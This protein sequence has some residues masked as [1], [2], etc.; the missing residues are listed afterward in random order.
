MKKLIFTIILILTFCFTVSAQ[1]NENDCQSIIIKAPDYVYT[2]TRFEVSAT[3]E[4]EIASDTSRFNWIIFNE[5]EVTRVKNKKFVD[6]TSKD[7]EKG[8][9]IIVIAESLDKKCET[10]S[11]AKINFFRRAGSPVIIAEFGILDWNE[12]KVRLDLAIFETTRYKDVELAIFVSYD[13][14]LRK[15][16]VRNYLSKILNHLSSRGLPKNRVTFFLEYSKDKKTELQLLPQELKIAS[17][18]KI[19][20]EYLI[21]RGEDLEKID[22]LFK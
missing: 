10:T 18:Y 12:E 21:I 6:I 13:N 16:G 5:G 14:S 9:T 17:I 20:E 7:S 2:E 19:Y 22:K 3:F 8:G 1:T 4:N 11:I 15:N